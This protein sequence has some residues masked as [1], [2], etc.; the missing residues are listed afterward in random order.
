MR[1]Y[2]NQTFVV[3]PSGEVIM[4]YYNFKKNVITSYAKNG[5]PTLRKWGWDIEKRTHTKSNYA[6]TKIKF[7]R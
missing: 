7:K 3:T 1:R 5:I 2:S 4:V 6:R